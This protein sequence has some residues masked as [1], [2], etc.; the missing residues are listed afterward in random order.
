M[1]F[2]FLFEDFKTF[3]RDNWHQAKIW[4]GFCNLDVSSETCTKH[5]KISAL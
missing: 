1:N 4:L 5:Q 2:S 3:K